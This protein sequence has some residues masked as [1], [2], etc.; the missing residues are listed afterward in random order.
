M[1]FSNC[2]VR[3]FTSAEVKVLLLGNVWLWLLRL[4]TEVVGVQGILTFFCISVAPV[5]SWN[6]GD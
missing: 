6:I 2:L 4:N 3:R 1:A 5:R